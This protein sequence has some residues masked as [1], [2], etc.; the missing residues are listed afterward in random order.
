MTP[1]KP[2]DREQAA[3]GTQ[4]ISGQRV[5]LSGSFADM[6]QRALS[7]DPDA[8]Q[9]DAA[10]IVSTIIAG[11]LVNE[12]ELR[13]ALSGRLRGQTAGLDHCFGGLK[14]VEAYVTDKQGE[15]QRLL[16][17]LARLEYGEGDFSFLEP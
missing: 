9:E 3:P 10:L 4:K 2:P 16:N 5:E 12:G 11:S 17:I 15:H 6:V 13:D 8:A 7:R 1:S 14:D